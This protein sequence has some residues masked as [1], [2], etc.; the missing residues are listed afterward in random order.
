MSG[1]AGV[2]VNP[3][4][5]TFAVTGGG[6]YCAGG[7]GVAVGLS[8]S[9]ANVNYL[10]RAN[11]SYNGV[12]VAG[13]G[14]ALSFGNQTTA[15]TYTVLASNS[16]TSCSQ[17]MSGSAGVTVNLSPVCTISPF[18][19][20]TC[21]GVAQTF[22]ASASGGTGPYSYLWNTTATTP[23]ITVSAAGTYT[24]TVTDA[25]GCTTQCAATLTVNPNPVCSVSP[26][27]AT[28]CASVARTFT[29]SVSGGTGPYSYLWNT[30]ATTPSIT[31]TAAGTYTVT[32]SDARGCT[33]QCS[34]TLTV[35]QPPLITSQPQ[36]RTNDVGSSTSFSVTAAG[37]APLL[38]QW[39]KDG[40]NLVD[41][42]G[43]TGVTTTD[44]TIA[45]V[46]ASNAGNY[47]VLVSNGCGTVT[48]APPASLTANT[49]PSTGIQFFEPFQAAAPVRFTTVG[50][51]WA[52]VDGHYVQSSLDPPGPYRSW[53]HV[54]NFT[55]YTLEVECTSMPGAE[56]KVIY[57]HGDTTDAYRVD[58]WL[59]RCRLSIPAWTQSWE[60]RNF[61][62]GGLDLAYKKPYSVKI[63]VSLAGVRVWVNYVLLHNQ[64]WAQNEPLGDGNVGV[65]TFAGAASFDNII[66]SL[67][68]IPVSLLDFRLT[69]AG[70]FFLSWRSTEQGPFTV[71]AST[72]MV[73]WTA[74]GNGTAQAGGT[75]EFLDT[76]SPVFANRFYR[77]K[78]QVEL[79]TG[80]LTIRA[81]A[82]GTDLDLP[83]PGIGMEDPPPFTPKASAAQ[84]KDRDMA[85]PVTFQVYDTR[86]KQ[87]IPLQRGAVATFPHT[88]ILKAPDGNPKHGEQ[89]A[90]TEPEDYLQFHSW[91]KVNKVNPV[92]VTLSYPAQI[93][94]FYTFFD[95]PP[96]PWP[97]QPGSSTKD[98]GTRAE[99]CGCN[100]TAGVFGPN[101]VQTNPLEEY[102]DIQ[103][104]VMESHVS[105][106]DLFLSHSSKD[107][108]VWILLSG[109]DPMKY[110]SQENG[111]WGERPNQI[112]LEWESGSWPKWARPMEYLLGP[113][114]LP[115]KVYGDIIWA[116]GKHIYDCGHQ[117]ASINNGA[118]TEIHPPIATAVMSGTQVSRD[119]YL[120]DDEDI[121]KAI[122]EQS[123]KTLTQGTKSI[124]GVQVD[125]WANSDPGPA[126]R[127]VKCGAAMSSLIFGGITCPGVDNLLDIKQTYTFE[128][129]L[130]PPPP[131]L[132]GEAQYSQFHW[133]LG[134]LESG[135][136]R[137][138]VTITP[139]NYTWQNPPTKLTVEVDLRNYTDHGTC[140][141]QAALY[142]EE[143]SNCGG[144]A[145]GFTLRAGWEV[146]AYP[147]DLRR[148]RVNVESLMV[149]HD[150]EGWGDGEF[151]VNL[152]IGPKTI[153]GTKTDPLPDDPGPIE[154]LQ[155]INPGLNDAHNGTPY[156]LFGKPHGSPMLSYLLNVRTNEPGKNQWTLKVEGYE[157]DVFCDDDF[158]NL[159]RKFPSSESQ[160]LEFQGLWPDWS[161]CDASHWNP[162]TVCWYYFETVFGTTRNIDAIPIRYEDKRMVDGEVIYGL[163]YWVSEEALPP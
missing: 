109:E 142:Q 149:Y 58:V 130:P 32:V 154:A 161:G 14:S 140:A 104:Q 88:V 21:A 84:R 59:D 11:G 67:G 159:G 141:R 136:P 8:G 145:Y 133:W 65:G 71:E 76:A 39:R 28:N 121:G 95:P 163:N 113:D 64:R 127:H 23:S 51:A 77:V 6:A 105:G 47:T 103:G 162:Q 143:L 2:T 119:F 93:D 82:A 128:V 158:G 7:S 83:W 17:V 54:G 116:R 3:L 101:W 110:L 115:P 62:V 52:I 26:P 97:P 55:E 79:P 98:P 9:Q 134:R 147:P 118:W 138:R 85:T 42:G 90:T 73:S 123:G 144:E 12:T 80:E 27:S 148:I 117:R 157:E 78:H 124:S 150:S 36:S 75:F 111:R 34:A 35:N 57:A 156:N 153:L 63:E 43:I 4:P 107:W 81:K 94:A 74:L 29:A 152:H 60:T 131:S 126:G 70:A 91:N 41:E 106:T 44:L 139:A 125:F 37:T 30:T 112:G 38:Y 18:S 92:K 61:T 87:W 50:G 49:L 48:S 40:A 86:Q 46:Q 1:S 96:L 53:V 137:P 72:N 122:G 114:E 15:A 13:T 155:S 66:L 100:W 20:T 16:T 33:T 19:A 108:N 56:T 31:V 24:V 89:L 132:N 160:F 68:N 135:Q 22:T 69:P 25:R 45:N 10:L 5:T 151:K 102:V 129:P 99:E 120:I 146:L